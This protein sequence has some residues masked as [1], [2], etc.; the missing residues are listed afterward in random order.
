MHM[1]P[2]SMRISEL[3]SNSRK[4]CCQGFVHKLKFLR[5]EH[6]GFLKH[7]GSGNEH[8]INPHFMVTTDA[9]KINIK[10]TVV[11]EIDYSPTEWIKYRIN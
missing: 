9:H 1:S 8:V 4:E 11:T 6:Q 2:E 5:L 3:G 10:V 7:T